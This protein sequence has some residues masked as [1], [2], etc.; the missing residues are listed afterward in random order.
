MVA[1]ILGRSNFNGRVG[2]NESFIA[3]F[4]AG[5]C[6]CVALSAGLTLAYALYLG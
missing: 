4:I 2:M 3:G 5:F 6:V 1:D